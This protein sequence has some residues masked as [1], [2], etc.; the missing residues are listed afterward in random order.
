MN[1][2]KHISNYEEGEL[3][4][5]ALND[6]KFVKITA[7]YIIYIFDVRSRIVNNYSEV[8]DRYHISPVEECPA[9]N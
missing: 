1:L 9:C 6:P 4:G 8:I 7:Q 3:L 5:L 2:E